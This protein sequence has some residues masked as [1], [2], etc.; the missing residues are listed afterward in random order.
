MK[1]KNY[2]KEN[3]ENRFN[4]HFSFWTGF[5][6]FLTQ[7]N[8]YSDAINH[9]T[10]MDIQDAFKSDVQQLHRDFR[11]ACKKNNLD[12]SSG[13]NRQKQLADACE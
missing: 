9:I 2:Y 6:A 10:H 7:R 13:K 8:P 11:V 3:F 12:F 5:F 4:I 1:D